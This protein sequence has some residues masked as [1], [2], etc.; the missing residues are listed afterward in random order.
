MVLPGTQSEN[1]FQR[2]GSQRGDEDLDHVWPP[3]GHTGP[4]AGAAEIFQRTKVGCGSTDYSAA[5]TTIERE[6]AGR[7]MLPCE[8]R[9]LVHSFDQGS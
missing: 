2:D 8:A 4:Y 7:G 5:E 6:N 9:A 1:G 3:F